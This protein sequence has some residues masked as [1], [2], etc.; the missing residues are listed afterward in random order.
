MLENPSQGR[1][2]L[3]ISLLNLSPTPSIPPLQVIKEGSFFYT[4]VTS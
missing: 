2:Y 1:I 3:Y 4:A